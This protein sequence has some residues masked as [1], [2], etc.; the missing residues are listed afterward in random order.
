MTFSSPLFPKTDTVSSSSLGTVEDEEVHLPVPGGEGQPHPLEAEE[1]AH[2]PQ[3]NCL[4]SAMMEA[5]SVV[6]LTAGAWKYLV[7]RIDDLI[8]HAVPD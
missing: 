1:A 8:K 4:T 2:I 3:V 5:H 6:L 7:G